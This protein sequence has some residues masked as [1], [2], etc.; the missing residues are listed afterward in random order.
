MGGYTGGYGGNEA[1]VLFLILI[2]LVLSTMGG[3]C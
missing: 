1:A 2:L 3:Y